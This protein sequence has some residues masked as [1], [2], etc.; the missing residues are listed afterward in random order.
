MIQ[1]SDNKEA[2][3]LRISPIVDRLLQSEHNYQDKFSFD[4]IMQV[5]S[6]LLEEVD[7]EEILNLKQEEL[8]N[9]IKRVIA[10]EATAG[11]LNDLTPEQ[12]EL[13]DAAVEGR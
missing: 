6:N 3:I 10:I 13:F 11:M 9:R 4:E 8:T 7:A 5:F 1:V 2:V 12:I